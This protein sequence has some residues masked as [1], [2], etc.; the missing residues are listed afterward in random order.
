MKNKLLKVFAL[1]CVTLAL[2]GCNKE[3]EIPPQNGEV[4]LSHN[5][6]EQLRAFKKQIEVVKINP[7]AKNGETISLTD[8]LWDVENYFNL[9]YSDVENYYAQIN[10]H[11]FTLSLPTDGQQQ[12]TVNDAVALYVQ[13]VVQAREALIS[14]DFDDKA[15]ISL[16]V[17][18][19]NTDSR[20]TLITFSGKTGSR[21]NH[22]PP[23]AHVEGPFGLDD[24]W[25]FA[26]PLGKCDDPDIP[27][28][29]DE[30]LQEQ[31]Y[32]ELIEPFIG[33]DVG[34]RNIYVNRRRFIFDGS[35]YAGVYYNTDPNNLCIPSDFMNDHYNAE[36]RII[37]Q[38]IPSQYQMTGYSPISIEIHGA[39]SGDF[40]V[41][42]RNEIEYGIR[43]EVDTDE[44][45]EIE[46][47]LIQQ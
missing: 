15:F 38:T 31:L 9:T 12:V 35:T 33:T 26:S 28:G 20:G 32:I 11:E 47:L 46:D 3:G 29:A 5:P 7:E 19:I 6:L 30:Q 36:K 34:S 45:G 17:K 8:A 23:Q 41:T 1:F 2:S 21:T 4:S 40:A 25:M 39:P 27:S 18:E 14:D 10:E 24:N 16:S 22:N 43:M 44:F 37:T 42:H 13:A